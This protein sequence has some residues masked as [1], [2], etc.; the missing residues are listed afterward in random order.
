M[1]ILRNITLVVMFNLLHL[2]Y[3]PEL[4]LTLKHNIYYQSHF[5]N[6]IQH[7]NETCYVKY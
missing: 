5:I 2:K 4:I 6:K 3:Y 1:N 7:F